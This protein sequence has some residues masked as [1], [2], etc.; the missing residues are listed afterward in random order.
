[1]I[2][3]DLGVLPKPRDAAGGWPG[4]QGPRMPRVG[5]SGKPSRLRRDEVAS[6]R[7]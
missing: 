2:L 5:G 4:I 3:V 7:P 1:M 6:D